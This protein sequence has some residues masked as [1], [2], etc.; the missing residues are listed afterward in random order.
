MPSK[1]TLEMIGHAQK[2]EHDK[3]KEA[4]KAGFDINSSAK[5]V[6]TTPAGPLPVD[7]STVLHEASAFGQLET[8]LAILELGA[9]VNQTTTEGWTPL[10][11]AIM[12]YNFDITTALTKHGALLDKAD[13]NGYTPKAMVSARNPKLLSQLLLIQASHKNY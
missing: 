13:C 4:I 10:H 8:V 1:T 3:I 12:N 5:C 2:G 11:A 6:S 9:N 7:G